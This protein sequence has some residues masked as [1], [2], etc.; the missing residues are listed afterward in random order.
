MN[1][2]TLKYEKIEQKLA[3][4]INTSLEA[5]EA[6]IRVAVYMAVVEGN[7]ILKKFEMIESAIV[8]YLNLMSYLKTKR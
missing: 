8:K 1:F 7:D 6:S 4:G 5:I 3:K 2:N